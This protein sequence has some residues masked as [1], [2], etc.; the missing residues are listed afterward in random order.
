MT[1][2]FNEDVLVERLVEECKKLTAGSLYVVDISPEFVYDGREETV[3]LEV[4][5]PAPTGGAKTWDGNDFQELLSALYARSRRSPL[6]Y[7]VTVTFRP[8]REGEDGLA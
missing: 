4:V 5:L 7:R 2:I 8:A 3:R 1:T 6:P